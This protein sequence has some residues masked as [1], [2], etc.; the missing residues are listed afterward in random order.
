MKSKVDKIKQILKDIETG[1]MKF[2][3]STTFEMMGA[4]YRFREMDTETFKAIGLNYDE[5]MQIIKYACYGEITSVGP[6][7]IKDYVDMFKQLDNISDNLTEVDLE[8]RQMVITFPTLHCFQN[9][10]FLLRNNDMY[11]MVNM[12]SCNFKVNFLKDMYL[13]YY[14]GLNIANQLKL[15]RG[16]TI[17]HI[18]VI[19]NIG[20]LHIY[21]K[22]V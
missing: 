4:H 6:Y 19:M 9:I 11:V 18:H 7:L 2:E 13:S 22:E 10:Q 8:T 17:N 1:I 20:S 12:R 16:C 5:I 15:I 3:T 21:K 14:C